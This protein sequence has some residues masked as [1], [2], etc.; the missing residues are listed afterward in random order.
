MVVTCQMTIILPF[1]GGIAGVVCPH[2]GKMKNL[3]CCSYGNFGDKIIVFTCL[4]SSEGCD[5][6]L[7]HLD[8]ALAPNKTNEWIKKQ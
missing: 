5:S 6:F 4:P 7:K 8:L 2:G 1:F 3:R